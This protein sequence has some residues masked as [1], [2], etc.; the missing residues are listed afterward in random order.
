MTECAWGCSAGPGCALLG[1]EGGIPGRLRW[2]LGLPA[3]RGEVV[4]GWLVSSWG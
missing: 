3:G 4:L 2:V 1:G